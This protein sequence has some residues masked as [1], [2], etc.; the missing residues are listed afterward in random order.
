MK[1]KE[2]IYSMTAL[3]LIFDQIIKL[4][5]KT[6]MNLLDQIK[7]IPNFFSI[8]YIENKGAAFS[9]LEGQRIFL[10]LIS[11][12]ILFIID[13]YITK[14]N[15]K[16]KHLIV[17]YGMIIAGILGNLIDRLLYDGVIDYLAFKIFGYDFPVFNLAD[18]C[19]VV[20]VI[21]LIIREFI[22]WRN[23]NDRNRIRK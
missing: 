17:Y 6:K 19:I 12:I 7:V 20:G 3:F 10:I 2:K 13:R 5:I 11:F 8:F 21:L 22:I 18:I 4:F 1:N 15:I 14:E 23:S 16:D 9:I